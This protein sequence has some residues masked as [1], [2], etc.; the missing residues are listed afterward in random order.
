MR[1][2]NNHLAR[3]L[4]DIDRER[5]PQPVWADRQGALKYRVLRRYLTNA[6]RLSNTVAAYLFEHA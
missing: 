3:N 6:Q 4:I 1:S 5:R 2:L